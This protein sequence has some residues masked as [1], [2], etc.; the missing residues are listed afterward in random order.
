VKELLQHG[1]LSAAGQDYRRSVIMY[2]LVLLPI[3][4][5]GLAIISL[6]GVEWP[7]ETHFVETIRLFA[8]DPSLRTL[9][10]YPEVTPPFV[11]GI[12]AL[13]GYVAGFDLSALRALS[14]VV[15]TLTFLLLHRLFFLATHNSLATILSCLFLI[16][17]PYMIGL[18]FFVSTDIMSLMFVLLAG[19]GVYKG[20]AWLFLVGASLALLCRQYNMYLLVAVGVYSL[21]SFI[22]GDRK[23][24]IRM[25][26]SCALSL[27]PLL[28]LIYIWEGPAPMDGIKKW[29][30]GNEPISF[31][32]N[33]VTAYVSLISVYAFPFILLRYRILIRS[34]AT[35]ILALLL[36]ATYIRFPVEPSSVVLAQTGRTTVGLFHRALQ[37]IVGHSVFQHL[38]FGILFFVG[39][40]VVL[41]VIEDAYYW[42]KCRSCQY[43]FFLD[44]MLFG[45]LL[46]MPFSY[47][48]WEK[49]LIHVLPFLALRLLLWRYSKESGAKCIIGQ[50]RTT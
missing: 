45:F 31:H 2:L 22:N 47:Q 29:V 14:L 26:I 39:I 24:S 42:V 25:M 49:Y 13:W 40:V 37:A 44:F 35:I 3:I 17:N 12:Y 23:A 27:L 38:I 7:D 36:S 34:K 46:V 28:V 48:L 4:G 9:S 15:S 50:F 18:S 20:N 33:Y 1:I 19:L 6:Q 43:E 8:A 11:F 21:C 5:I 32:L 10:N 30:P 41:N 16:L